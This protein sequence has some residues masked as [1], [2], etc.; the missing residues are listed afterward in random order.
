VILTGD[1]SDFRLGMSAQFLNLYSH[2]K[3]SIYATQDANVAGTSCIC[4]YWRPLAAWTVAKRVNSVDGRYYE[5]QLYSWLQQLTERWKRR[6]FFPISSRK[7][8]VG[9][10]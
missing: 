4:T 1:A 10:L 3:G 7:R 9:Y 6:I 5:Q 8:Q 2:S